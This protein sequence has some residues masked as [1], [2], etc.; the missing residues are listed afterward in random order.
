MGG[1]WSVDMTEAV[2]RGR[3]DAVITCNRNW[4]L[5][6]QC[7]ECKNMPRIHRVTHVRPALML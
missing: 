3:M 5:D 7:F 1:D 6:G 4:G 2:C